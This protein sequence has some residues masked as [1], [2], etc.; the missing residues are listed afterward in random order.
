MLLVLP[1]LLPLPMLLV[2]P[3]LL[4]L[5]IRHHSLLAACIIHIY[6]RGSSG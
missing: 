1:M 2:L 4:P 5:L 6:R 3:M